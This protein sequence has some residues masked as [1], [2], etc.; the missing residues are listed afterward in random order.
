M[1]VSK[2]GMTR[3]FNY[4]NYNMLLNI[5]YNNK[6]SWDAVKVEGCGMDMHWNLQFLTCQDLATKGEIEKHNLNMLC[7]SG[8]VL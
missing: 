2:S 5:C 7:S 6:F 3:K 8:S 1:H 4:R